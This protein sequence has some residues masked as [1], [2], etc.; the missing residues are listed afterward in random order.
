MVTERRPTDVKDDPPDHP[1]KC[2]TPVYHLLNCDRNQA[3]EALWKVYY[4]SILNSSCS[5]WI[6]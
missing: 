4:Y 5:Q 6:V 3:Y 2:P 1:Q